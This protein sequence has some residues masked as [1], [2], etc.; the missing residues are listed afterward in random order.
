MATPTTF[1]PPL[2]RFRRAAAALGGR[3]DGSGAGRGLASEAA[4]ALVALATGGDAE[5]LDATLRPDPIA[6]DVAWTVCCY[7][8]GDL[9][10]SALRDFADA[11]AAVRTL[12]TCDDATHVAA[13]LLACGSNGLTWT[14]MTRLGDELTFQLLDASTGR[15]PSIGL[16]RSW[17]EPSPSG[18]APGPTALDA[19]RRRWENLLTAWSVDP[20]AGVRSAPSVAPVSSGAAVSSGAVPTEVRLRL[21]AVE[22]Q[23]AALTEQVRELRANADHRATS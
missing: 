8:I 16:D 17:P 15:D 23:L 22:A 10:P 3:S 7:Q 1:D 6:G 13:E 19:A 11:S 14:A 5:V 9:S 4:V 20:Y 21:D 2:I 12:A 18:G